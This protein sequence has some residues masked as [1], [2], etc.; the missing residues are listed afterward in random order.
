MITGWLN[1]CNLSSVF[2]LLFS[3]F[4]TPNFISMASI[5]IHIKLVGMQ[6]ILS[7]DLSNWHVLKL[8]FFNDLIV[9]V[10]FFSNDLFLYSSCPSLLGCCLVILLLDLLLPELSS[11]FSIHLFKDFIVL[12]VMIESNQ[13]IKE[14]CKMKI[15]KVVEFEPEDQVPVKLCITNLG[16]WKKTQINLLDSFV[17]LVNSQSCFSILSEFVWLKK[18]NFLYLVCSKLALSINL[19]LGTDCSEVLLILTLLWAW[20]LPFEIQ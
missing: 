11:W 3:K 9:F 14:R 18:I 16:L 4:G 2:H 13:M 6:S 5:F 17:L 7:L 12:S 19:D 15:R 1:S 20:F 8:L 10:V